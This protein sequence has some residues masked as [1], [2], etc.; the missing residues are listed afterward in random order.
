L[1]VRPQSVEFVFLFT[2]LTQAMVD[3]KSQ[4]MTKR[5]RGFCLEA[6]IFC[7]Q[8]L[9][10]VNMALIGLQSDSNFVVDNDAVFMI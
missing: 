10:I 5:R 8:P 1:R 6:L 9:I 3:K 2:E 7:I 4:S